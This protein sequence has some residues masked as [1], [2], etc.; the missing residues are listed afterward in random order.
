[1]R[2]GNKPSIMTNDDGQLVAVNLSADFC[3]EHEWGIRDLSNM[4]GIRGDQRAEKILGVTRKEEMIGLDARQITRFNR[5]DFVFNVKDAQLPDPRDKRKKKLKTKISYLALVGSSYG[6]ETIEERDDKYFFDGKEFMSR[7]L[8][9]DRWDIER[10][11]E[12][13]VEVPIAAA[14]SGRDF[15]VMMEGDLGAQYIT[16]LFEACQLKDICILFSRSLPVFENAGMI[17]AIRSRLPD[18]DEIHQKL[19]DDVRSNWALEDRVNEIGIKKKI[20]KINIEYRQKTGGWNN[21][22]GYFALSPQW[23]GDRYK[24]LD[25]KYDVVF[26]LNPMDQQENGFGWYTVEDLEAWIKGEGPIPGSGRKY[27]KS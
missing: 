19:S 9:L 23:K 26:W 2:R 27:K 4:L 15:G 3:A 5:E 12:D 10:Q 11:K 6:K 21:P 22:L 17:L 24:D 20:D 13:G 25:T 7:E 16:E 18:A 8:S 14:W 1:M